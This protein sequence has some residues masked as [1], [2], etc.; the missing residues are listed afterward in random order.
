MSLDFLE[1]PKVN[2][3][4][5]EENW[6]L[7]N[8]SQFFAPDSPESLAQA[9]KNVPE[10]GMLEKELKTMSADIRTR[11]LAQERES[12]RRIAEL[13]MAGSLA[14]AEEKGR[15]AGKAEGRE[16]GREEGDR[17]R[18]RETVLAMVDDGISR[19]RICKICKIT[20]A[21]L[22]TILASGAAPKAS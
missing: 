22:T 1:L 12:D 6:L 4:M 9:V 20:E 13:A 19:E 18:L 3:S 8:W 2:A 11:Q 21:E 5:M 15:E 14:K 10:L 17:N 7:W 16:E